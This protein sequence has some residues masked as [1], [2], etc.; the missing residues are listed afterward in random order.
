LLRRR[1]SALVILL[2]AK[3]EQHERRLAAIGGKDDLV[4]Y[5]R[6]S[7]ALRTATAYNGEFPGIHGIVVVLRLLYARKRSQHL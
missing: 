3:T 1:G 7:R 5:E 4:S 2:V 6:Q